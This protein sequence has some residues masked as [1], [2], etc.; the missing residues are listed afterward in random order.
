MKES[1]TFGK[2]LKHV[3]EAVTENEKKVEE[4]PI[5]PVGSRLY[6]GKP[7]MDEDEYFSVK[8]Y[9]ASYIKRYDK[10]PSLLNNL[11]YP[12]KKIEKEMEGR[13]SRSKK[14]GTIL[15]KIFLEGWKRKDFDPLLSTD[16]EKETVDALIKNFSTHKVVGQIMKDIKHAEKPIFWKEEIR[17]RKLHCKAKIDLL[18]NLDALFEVKTTAYLG[19][20][21]REIDKYRYDL[22]MSFYRRGVEEALGVGVIEC[23]II[24]LETSPPYDV[25]LFELDETYLERGEKGGYIRRAQVSGWRELLEEMHF[26][27]RKRFKEPITVL[28]LNEGEGK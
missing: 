23:G 10:N 2:S 7:Q 27:P 26:N 18:T 6:E 17:G 9:S 5:L 20:F 28:T 13:Q 19:D 16:K 25:H 3:F 8:G 22:Q 12:Q 24:A 14:I 4:T 1:D 11:Y 15:H 21:E